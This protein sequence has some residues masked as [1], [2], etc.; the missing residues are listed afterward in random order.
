MPTAEST[1]A[2]TALNEL[3]DPDADEPG[4]G[5]GRNPIRRGAAPGSHRIGREN[6]LAP[7][8]TRVCHI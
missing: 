1:C 2:A 3:G 5:K 7:W 8:P 4:M 6:G